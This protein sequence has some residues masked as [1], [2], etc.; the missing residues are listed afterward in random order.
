MCVACQLYNY[1]AMTVCIRNFNE[2]VENVKPTTTYRPLYV[3]FCRD[4]DNA[5]CVFSVVHTALI[6]QSPK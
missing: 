4:N 6:L 1:V 2:N 3:A 5:W